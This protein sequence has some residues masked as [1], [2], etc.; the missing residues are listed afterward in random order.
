MSEKVVIGVDFGTQSARA[1]AYR[2]DGTPVAQASEAYPTNYPGPN[3]AE[4][5][6]ADWWAA[7]CRAVP[8]CM[9]EGGLTA[10]DVAAIACDGTSY[11]GVYCDET[12]TP[13]RPAL[14]WMDLRAGEEAKRVESEDHPVLDHC[15][16]RVSPEWLLPKTLWIQKHEPEVYRGAARIVEGVDWIVYGLTGRWVTATGSAAGKRH[17]TPE[18]VWPTDFY[19]RLGV[20][21]L[22]NKSPDE[23]VYVGDVVGTLLP[24]AADALGLS[25]GCVVSHAGM[26]GWT[27]PIGKNC[28]APGCA[29][30]TLGTSTVVIVETDKP[31]IIDGVMGPF[32]EGIRRGWSVYEAGQTSG[33][34]TVG[35]CLDL[36]GAKDSAAYGAL[37][38]QARALPPGADGLVV[39]DAWRGNRTPYY[40]PNA[41]GTICGLTLDHTPAH[42]YRAV[43]EGC[44]FAIRNVAATLNRGLTQP[45]T[46]F[47]A[48]GT[49]AGNALWTELIAT[50]TGLPVLVSAEKHATCLGSAMCA[51]V[52]CGAHPSIEAAAEA[53]QPTFETVEPVQGIGVYDDYFAAYVETYAQ[54]KHTMGRLGELARAASELTNRQGG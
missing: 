50:I 5:N 1:A 53:M 41:R 38:Q 31:A 29:S 54:M 43:L 51:A 11:T 24:E 47:R 18:N 2:A 15:G 13:L 22:V 3:R 36:L 20:P 10:D 23:V 12:G 30:L 40:D 46:E 17:W 39:F 9:Q 16:R 37:E 6:P 7:V 26:D 21:D 33:G 49:G 14:L 19:D 52:A 35:W 48:C 25:P 4:Q 27:S 34:S 28:F 44:S 32:P 45:V 42:I 8:R